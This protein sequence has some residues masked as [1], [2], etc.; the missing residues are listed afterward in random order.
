MVDLSEL[1]IMEEQIEGTVESIGE[2]EEIETKF[3]RN[4]RVPIAVKTKKA[5]IE[6]NVWVTERSLKQGILHPRSN[7]YKLLTAYKCKSLKELVGKK[8]TLRVDS[9]GFYRLVY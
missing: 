1:E 7:L 3:G 5:T 8:V 6:T 4:Y 9:R 2:P